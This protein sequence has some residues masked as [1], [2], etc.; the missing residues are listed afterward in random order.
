MIKTILIAGVEN[1]T[2]AAIAETFRKKNFYVYGLGMEEGYSAHFD[3]FIQ[4]D[5]N[6]F[7]KEAGFR[8]KASEQL[9]EL[10]PTLDVL[11]NSASVRRMDGLQDVKLEDWQETLNVNLTGPML[12]S[13]LFL[14]KLEAGKGCIIHIAP[15]E[16]SSLKPGSLANTTSGSALHGLS[17]AMAADL[18]GRVRVNSISFSEN[19]GAP[20]EAARLAFFLATESQGFI[21]GEN[22]AVDGGIY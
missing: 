2:G 1:E 6:R 17:R 15:T 10:I 3:R 21:H 4:F 22:I 19:P 13:K 18:K 12:L 7:V 20:Q 11:V 8:I 9:G 14:P 16:Q 5:M